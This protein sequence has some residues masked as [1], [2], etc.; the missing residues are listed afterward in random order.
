MVAVVDPVAVRERQAK[1]AFGQLKGG[2]EV[3]ILEQ[4]IDLLARRGDGPVTPP[5]VD[6][7]AGD[8]AVLIEQPQ[9]GGRGVVDG[10]D[11]GDGVGL[12]V[13]GKVE[14]RRGLV[15]EGVAG[16]GHRLGVRVCEKGDSLGVILPATEGGGWDVVDIEVLL[17][18]AT[19]V[20]TGV[21]RCRGRVIGRNVVYSMKR[22]YHRIYVV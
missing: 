4:A 16:H 10:A 5:V 8:L 2:V 11:L 21:Y 22:N 12:E 20:P 7:L 14:H 3:E 19:T 15:H 6:V 1:G 18:P 13:V 17:W 9:R